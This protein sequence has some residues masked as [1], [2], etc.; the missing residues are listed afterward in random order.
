MKTVYIIMTLL[1]CFT[2]LCQ[3]PEN[4]EDKKTTTEKFQI[5]D[6]FD[7]TIDYKMISYSELPGRVKNKLNELDI[8][9]KTIESIK[10]VT[11]KNQNLFLISY[12]LD[13]Q[14]KSIRIKPNGKI[15]KG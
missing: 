11:L 2:G 3:D 4:N 13:D 10:A 5:R 15:E 12:L 1:I 9:P 14:L 8:K 6:V 7:K